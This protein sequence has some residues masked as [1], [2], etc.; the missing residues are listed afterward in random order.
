MVQE[1]YKTTFIKLVDILVITT[2]SMLSLDAS[3]NKAPAG[4]RNLHLKRP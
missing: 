1:I 3:L 2:L 4:T